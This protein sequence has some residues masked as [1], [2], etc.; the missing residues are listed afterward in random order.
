MRSYRVEPENVPLPAR[1]TG[2]LRALAHAAINES[3]PRA[4][5]CDKTGK[6]TWNVESDRFEIGY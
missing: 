1:L 6:L 5:P 3:L 2:Q 4:R